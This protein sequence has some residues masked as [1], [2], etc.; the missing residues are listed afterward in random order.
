LLRLKAPS[1]WSVSPAQQPFKLS[2]AGDQNKVAFTITPPPSGSGS[3]VAV[4]QIGDAQFSNQRIEIRYDH[5]PVQLLQPP[6]KLKVIALDLAIRGK[7]VGYLPGAGDDT[8]AS[9]EQL[10]Y[11]VT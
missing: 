4:A 8:V 9:L 1:G 11:T 5:I 3:L 7:A 2:K 10:G 6:A